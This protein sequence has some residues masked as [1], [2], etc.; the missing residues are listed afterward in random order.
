MILG[1]GTGTLIL[2]GIILFILFQAVNILQE[3]ER[4]V[5]FFLGRYQKVKGPGLVLIF[6]GIQKMVKL[7]LRTV[8]LDIP[9][10]DVITR[11]NV[12]IKVNAVVYFR[13]IAPEKALI[14]VENYLY[15]T[16]QL[17]QTTLRSVC[18]QGEMDELLSA[19]EK[20]NKQLR[21]SLERQTT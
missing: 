1:I 18:G 10:Q 4:G 3:Y 6:P 17:A 12:T 20:K 9:P 8:T 5:V 14:A 13:V 15:A 19:R 21:E 16:S 11:D 7:S 2:V